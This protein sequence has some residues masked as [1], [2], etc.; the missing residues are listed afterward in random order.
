[1]LTCTS[2]AFAHS[3]RPGVCPT[4]TGRSSWV[5]RSR[6]S[7]TGLVDRLKPRR[8]LDVDVCITRNIFAKLVLRDVTPRIDPMRRR[9][10]GPVHA[11]SRSRI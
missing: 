1:M 10:D 7:T 2:R 5:A 4:A 11:L 6:R 8:M 3:A 9:N